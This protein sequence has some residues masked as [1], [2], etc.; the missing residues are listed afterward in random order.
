LIAD[1]VGAMAQQPRDSVIAVVGDGFGSLQVFTTAVYLGFDPEQIAIYGPGDDPVGTYGQFAHNLG[2]TVLR[3]ESESH[4]LPADWPTFAQ[5][6]AWSRKSIRPLLRSIR[7]RYNPG[8]AEILNEATA[9]ARRLGW[10]QSRVSSRVGWLQREND[11]VPHLSLYDEDANLMGRAK[12][13]V[14]ALGHGPLNFPPALAR[15]RENPEL[16]P[17]VVQAYEPKA[18]APGGRYI[19]V[20]AG[21]AAVNE[22][23]NA[24][25]AGGQV[26][27]L[28]RGPV[29]EELRSGLGEWVFGCDVCQEVCPW[30]RK[31]PAMPEP[32]LQPR[33]EL[34]S[35]NLLALLQ[36]NQEEFEETF[37]STP[38]ERSG[39]AGLL[40][41]AALVLGNRGDPTALPALRQALND[42]EPLVREAARWAIEQIERDNGLL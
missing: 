25:D 18:Y 29:P 39:R 40:R 12:H 35:L 3:S 9:V 42:P 34:A 16:A 14:L 6:D 28:L 19:V 20:G 17:R 1:I 36:L 37:G 11:D 2:Q 8:V 22:W 4:F 7:R 26:I 30:N 38:L 5:L 15:A 33:P 10:H 27:S 24:L 13:V 31:A 21:I 32:A 23:A 41:N